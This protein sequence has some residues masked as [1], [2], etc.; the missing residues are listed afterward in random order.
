[1]IC[2]VRA[3][4]CC[5]VGVA[6]VFDGD[7]A[8][9]SV[10][11]NRSLDSPAESA[12]STSAT[13]HASS[14]HTKAD[15]YA[16]QAGEYG[17]S[18][19]DYRTDDHS[20]RNSRHVNDAPNGSYRRPDDY[21]RREPDG[22]R[23]ER[24]R[25]RDRDRRDRDRG[26]GRGRGGDFA[27]TP[28]S[29][30]YPRTAERRSRTRS[31]SPSRN[32]VARRGDSFRG[33]AS[34]NDTPRYDDRS[35]TY[36]P[37][38]AATDTDRDRMPAYGSRYYNDGHADR[39]KDRVMD[40]DVL[41]RRME[42]AL[43]RDREKTYFA[44]GRSSRS[45]SPRPY[46]KRPK[47]SRERERE[48]EPIAVNAFRQSLDAAASSYGRDFSALDQLSHLSTYPYPPLD[49][50]SAAASHAL[51][52]LSQFAVAASLPHYGG[53]ATAAASLRASS[54]PSSRRSSRSPPRASSA[55]ARYPPNGR[56]YSS[57]SRAFA[58]SSG[59]PSGRGGGRGRGRDRDD[60]A[61]G[62]RPYH[63]SR[64]FEYSSNSNSNSNSS[65]HATTPQPTSGVALGSAA[66][67]S[68]SSAGAGGSE[69]KVELPKNDYCQHFVDTGER[70]Q[71]FIRDAN[72]DDR[73]QEYVPPVS[74]VCLFSVCLG[75]LLF[76]CISAM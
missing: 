65:S 28:G 17:G 9:S 76:D 69:S 30:T 20:Y 6:A 73:F 33:G 46:P 32:L 62:N 49:I 66:T 16:K 64:N 47:Y 42:D 44:R 70:P 5:W 19:N 8:S 52:R 21:P 60:D 22:A 35:R 50:T 74:A 26:G 58:S 27:N 38:P 57:S 53:L 59:S 14:H 23:F 2:C 24:D 15:S 55:G 56:E 41:G 1:M 63:R 72:V 4:L 48:P 7:H 31:R 25:D 34:S 12:V 68:S 75:S 43:G 45:L 11:N 67:S 18:N 37:A 10:D 39:D 36:A 13:L 51:H 29:Q 61:R 40:R 71:N 54:G 3:L